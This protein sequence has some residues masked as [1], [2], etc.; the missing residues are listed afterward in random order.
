MPFFWVVVII[1]VVWWLASQSKKKTGIAPIPM[2]TN[3]DEPVSKITEETIFKVQSRFEEKL[4]K[5]IDFPDAIR[6]I[7]IYIYRNLMRPWYDKLS[8]QN[9]YNE[10]MAQKL[11]RDWLDYMSAVE[12][13]STTN[14]LSLE[15][16]DEKDSSKSD[17]YREEHV[18]A[19]R[20]MFAI[21]DAF[22]ASVGQEAIDE[23][24]R[25]RNLDF[26]AI[27]K[28]GNL[29]PEGFN[30]DLMGKLHPIKNKK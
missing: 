27:D 22:A 7:E 16:Y 21:E 3:G 11:C 4:T 12:D 10:E 6:G 5:E 17:S 1:I 28:F 23:L 20:K 26:Y 15:F 29:A 9:R 13:R 25:V 18:L 30:F 19:S 14:Y 24:N 8:S 2:T